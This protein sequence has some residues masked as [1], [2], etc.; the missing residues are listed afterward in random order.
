MDRPDPF[1]PE[2]INTMIMLICHSDAG[3]NQWQDPGTFWKEIFKISQ[4]MTQHPKVN[5][6]VRNRQFAKKNY[7]VRQNFL[8]VNLTMDSS[9]NLYDDYNAIS[10]FF[11]TGQSFEIFS[12]KMTKWPYVFIY[13]F[14]SFIIT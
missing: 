10:R 14:L 6:Q 13:V 7:T 8:T 3:K 12:V 1:P 4:S 11:T 2:E 5:I 9:R